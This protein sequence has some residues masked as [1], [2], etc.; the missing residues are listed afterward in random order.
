MAKN[1]SATDQSTSKF[2]LL[3]TAAVYLT[4]GSLERKFA[5]KD[6]EFEAD[7]ANL[8]MNTQYIASIIAMA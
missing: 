5:T 4:F 2:N 6:H 8:M 1:V 3:R 7:G